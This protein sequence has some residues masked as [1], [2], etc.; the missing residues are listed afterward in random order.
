MEGCK[1]KYPRLDR[2]NPRD[3]EGPKK[4]L[5]SLSRRKLEERQ[6]KVSPFSFQTELLHLCL[7]VKQSIQ[8]LQISFFFKARRIS[9]VTHILVPTEAETFR[10]PSPPTQTPT[11]VH[12]ELH[13]YCTD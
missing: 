6:T 10:P 12:F 4:M 7:N 11:S 9:S 5:R 1:R 3:E 2:E 13:V 8:P